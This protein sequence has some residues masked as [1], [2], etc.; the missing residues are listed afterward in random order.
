VEVEEEESGGSFGMAPFGDAQEGLALFGREM[1]EG[2]KKLNDEL[3][4]LGEKGR[5][6]ATGLKRFVRRWAT[7][8]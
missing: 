5:S 7:K 4:L 3:A 2:M 6:T 1:N 8:I